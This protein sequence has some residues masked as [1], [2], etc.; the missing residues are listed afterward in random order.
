MPF[1]GHV[2]CG[3]LVAA[4]LVLAAPLALARPP[5]RPLEGV[6]TG[7]ATGCSGRGD[8]PELRLA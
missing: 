4:S 5:A 1:P 2:A 7:T 3:S 6:W 8:A